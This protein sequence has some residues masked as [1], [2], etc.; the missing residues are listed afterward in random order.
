MPNLWDIHVGWFILLAG[1]A[2]AFAIIGLEWWCWKERTH[3]TKDGG[4]QMSDLKA[5]ALAITL[6]NRLGLSLTPEQAIG[7]L[8]NGKPLADGMNEG[9]LWDTINT[10]KSDL[11]EAVGLLRFHC[12]HCKQ[13]IERVATNR[14]LLEYCSNCDTKTLIDKHKENKS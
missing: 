2:A 8:R 12:R 7:I 9:V 11:D 13:G 10:L 6:V 3:L 4:Q 5:Q 14:E 1:T